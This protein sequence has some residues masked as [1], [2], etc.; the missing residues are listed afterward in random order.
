MD[1]RMNAGHLT[2]QEVI[3]LL[4]SPE[5]LSTQQR[6]AFESHLASCK[7]CE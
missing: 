3:L 2:E 7:Y 5:Q 6:E 4:L 1:K